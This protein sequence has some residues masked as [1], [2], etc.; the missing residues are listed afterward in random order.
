MKAFEN[1]EET[2]CISVLL[3]LN[4]QSFLD[5]AL[6][7]ASAAAHHGLARVLLN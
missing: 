2:L 5:S 6:H 1:W 4:G 7:S 3:M